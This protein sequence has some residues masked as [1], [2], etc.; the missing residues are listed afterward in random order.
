MI[1]L[2]WN[3]CLLSALMLVTLLSQ[4]HA[5]ETHHGQQYDCLPSDNLEKI[6]KPCALNRPYN[7]HDYLTQ[8]QHIHEM[9][10]DLYQHHYHTFHAV[11]NWLHTGADIRQLNQAGLSARQMHGVDRTGNVQFTGYYTPVIQARHTAQK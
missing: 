5:R 8:M 1:N 7:I 11:K 4:S 9:S 10:P 6:N 3:H 2:H